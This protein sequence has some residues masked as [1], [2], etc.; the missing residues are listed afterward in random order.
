MAEEVL[1]T[2]FEKSFKIWKRP[3]NHYLTVPPVTHSQ[4][5]NMVLAGKPA[6]KKYKEKV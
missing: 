5:P 2:D 6:K 3:K 1:R 4:P